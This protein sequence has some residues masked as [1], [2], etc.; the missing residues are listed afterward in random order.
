MNIVELL[1]LPLLAVI[2]LTIPVI[3]II[4]NRKGGKVAKRA[5]LFNLC[6]FFAVLALAIILPI[7][8]FITLGC[9]IALMQYALKKSEKKK[10]K[11]LAEQKEK[12]AA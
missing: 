5:F 12:E 1:L 11:A 7:G 10:E 9:L 6:R 3:A 2:L 4:R 8:G